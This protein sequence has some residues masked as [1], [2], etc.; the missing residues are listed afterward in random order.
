MGSCSPSPS[1]FSAERVIGRRLLLL[2]LLL[3]GAEAAAA[4]A[5]R[6]GAALARAAVDG[7]TKALALEEQQAMTAAEPSK[8]AMQVFMM[9]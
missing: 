8:E 4:A 2:V 9:S 5:T 7:T 6:V 1:F 3:V